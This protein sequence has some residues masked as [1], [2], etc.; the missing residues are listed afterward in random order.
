MC[1]AV[2][3]PKEE[4]EIWTDLADALGLIPEYPSELA[5]LALKDRLEYA[6][7]LMDYIGE[8]ALSMELL[9]FIVG[10][11]LGK[12]LNSPALS[13]FWSVLVQYCQTGGTE[14]E[15]AGYT[16]SP[17]LAEELFQ[18]FIDTP[19]DILVCVQDM[20]NNI[21]DSIKTPDG[22]V[23]LHIPVMDDWVAKIN[24]EDELEALEST[25][26]PMLLAAGERTD[27]NSNS[28]MRNRDWIGDKQVCTMRIHP[29]DA[30]ELGVETGATALVETEAASLEV[31]VEVSDR[32]CRG[33]VI[34]PHGFGLEHHGQVEGVN[35]NYLTS[36]RNRDPF[37][38][39]PLH[40]FIPCKV[41]AR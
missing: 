8:N 4:A 23:H 18:R 3:E 30:K 35:V 17:M 10:K 1:D 38:A 34:I 20:K 33:M 6:K 21:A 9:H 24:P 16:P 25:G 19:G 36:A 28:R 26:Y 5:G 37:T 14:L 12:A 13:F 40:K 15:R 29:D 2:G 7:A 41:S 32:P 27:F 22:K 11:T 39:T 31:E